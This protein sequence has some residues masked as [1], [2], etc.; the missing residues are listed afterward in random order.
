MPRAPRR[1]KPTV[2]DLQ[3]NRERV[4]LD[5]AATKV[6]PRPI[7]EIRAEKGLSTPLWA[8]K[9]A[10]FSEM[11]IPQAGIFKK[12][13]G[14]IPFKIADQAHKHG[15]MTVVVTGGIRSSKSISSAAEAVAWSMHSDLIWFAGD[16]Y[17]L[18]RQEFEYTMEAMISLGWTRKSNISLPRSKYLPCVLETNWG[19]IIETRSLNDVNTFVARA[20]DIILL[21]EPGLA[22]PDSVQK[23]RERLSTKAGRLW[24]AGTFEEARF[25][26]LEDYWRKGVRWPN[27]ESIKSFTIPT[28]VNRV[29]F[30][31]GKA[32]PG[33]QLLR[34]SCRS[35]DEF[36]LRCGGVPIPH[37]SQ[38]IGDVWN[39]KLHTGTVP[40]I[41]NYD[42]GTRW[43]VE[44]AID[45][46]YAGGS[47]YSVLA[48]QK[49]PCPKCN[50]QRLR[51][52]DE[53]ATK[54]TEYQ[55]VIEIAKKREWWP[56]VQ[57]GTCDPRAG[58]SHVFGAPS[59]QTVWYEEAGVSLVLPERRP[60][61]ECIGLIKDTLHDPVHK[62]SHLIVDKD[63]TENF[64]KEMVGWRRRR[65]SEGYGKPSDKDCDSAKAFGYYLTDWWPKRG[66]Q[67]KDLEMSPISVSDMLFH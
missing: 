67:G 62:H 42:N 59:P 57:A 55:R 25:N 26:W 61:E 35:F 18:S 36:L 49:E 11:S 1:K 56:A 3:A 17:D 64:Q 31:L 43:P 63:R 16:T 40:Y 15:A 54:N 46:G 6:D 28:W 52:I 45:P 29:S 19:T 44:I 65:T 53:I 8:E 41:R 58:G 32:D 37:Q 38:V 10:V 66:N 7:W 4:N 2:T 39:E 27:P 9:Q 48:F 60:V 22:S 24:A 12:D 51:M 33:I 47:K 5:K 23:A 30:P 14:Y 13:G 50:G 21:C 34:A 20:P